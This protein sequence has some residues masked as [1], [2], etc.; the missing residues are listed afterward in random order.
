VATCFDLIGPSSGLHYG[1][2]NYKAAYILGIPK[3][4]SQAIIINS[5]VSIN[6]Q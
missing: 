3:Q 4:C 6:T 1:P 2:I 5:S